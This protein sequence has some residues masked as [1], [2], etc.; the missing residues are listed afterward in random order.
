MRV[1]ILL[2]HMETEQHTAEKP[3]WVTEE[4]REEILNTLESNENENTRFSATQQK[5]C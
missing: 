5:T 1:G 2:P 3:V 4:I